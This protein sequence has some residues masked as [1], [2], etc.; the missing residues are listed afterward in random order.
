M[1]AETTVTGDP[2]RY[3]NML[4]LASEFTP[5]SES[6]TR[7]ALPPVPA[8]VCD[9]IETPCLNSN[10]S[11][12]D[13]NGISRDVVDDFQEGLQ[14][15]LVPGGDIQWALSP[16]MPFT[17]LG[18]ESHGFDGPAGI[19]EATPSPSRQITMDNPQVV[20]CNPADTLFLESP[21]SSQFE[22]QPAH[23][24]EATEIWHWHLP[25]GDNPPESSY[26]CQDPDHPRILDT[27]PHV[28]S[29]SND[30]M[31]TLKM[32]I[33]ETW[34]KLQGGCEN[35][36][37]SNDTVTLPGIH[38]KTLPQSQDMLSHGRIGCHHVTQI[39][40]SY[41]VMDPLRCF[42]TRPLP[43]LSPKNLTYSTR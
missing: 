20:F 13:G 29:H 4:M 33:W 1:S 41:K 31:T 30:G 39:I 3:G 25:A 17:L 27:L 38:I 2:G 14:Q 10:P 19:T 5:P 36:V 34:D 24:D 21:L 12:D 35:A 9:Y 11:Y 37:P 6:D 8:S 18:L 42:I 26:V 15:S 7:R 43:P 32:D 16:P 23:A 22:R 28:E 40:Q